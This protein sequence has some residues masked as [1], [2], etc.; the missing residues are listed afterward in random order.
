MLAH[1]SVSGYCTVG[2]G[3]QRRL[4]AVPVTLGNPPLPKED[5]WRHNIR[6]SKAGARDSDK[7]NHS[8]KEK[9]MYVNTG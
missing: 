8:M 5:P 1:C 9:Q 2:E 3:G 6:F 4:V 7:D